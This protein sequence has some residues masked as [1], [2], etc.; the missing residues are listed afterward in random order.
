MAAWELGTVVKLFRKHT[1]LSQ[2]GVAR[3]VNIDQAEVSRLERGLK[4]IRDR[5]QFV[6]WTDALGVPKEL[7]GLLPT[8]DPHVPDSQG[9]TGT[10]DT[11]AHGY[12]ALPEGPGQLLLPAGR[13]LSTTA[14]PVLTLPAASFL[15]DSLML[16]S[17]PELGAWRTMP[18]RALI[19]ANRTVDGTVRQFVTDA[20]PSGARAAASDP[21]DIPAAYELD[22]L[23]YG[24]LWAVS[25]FEAALLGD[26]QALHAPLA[27]LTA[28]PGSPV[29]S[30]QAL[31][32]VSRMLIGSETCARYILGH[33][34]HLGDSPVFWTREQR[35]EEAATWL[36]FRHKYQ[37]LER[38]APRR[39]GGA[40]GRGFCIPETAV[41]SS[42]AYERVLLF[43]AIALM[44]SFGIRTWVT[45]D[46]GFAHT[47]GFALSPGRRAVIASWV[48][49]EGGIPP[50]GHRA[51][52]NPAHVR[53]RDRPCQPPLG[54]GGRAGRTAPC[55]NGGVPQSRRLL[56]RAAVR[57]AFSRR[58]GTARA[59]AQPVARPRRAGRRLPVRGRAA[60][61]R[62]AYPDGADPIACVNHS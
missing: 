16:D 32:D 48:R 6:Q 10:A 1:G 17:R 41:V 49:T 34:D 53:R 36:F 9:R 40:S 57:T 56:A 58:H 12:A 22:D 37:Y 23:T 11:R 20:R 42:P 28:S 2:A 54:H 7:L 45:D 26:D 21:V 50:R 24:I 8:A 13:S 62:S 55:G 44:E 33:R 30:D 29:A 46:G 4:Q 61:D 38:T 19:V 59:A 15:G 5:R 27:S 18:M 25:G 51:A 3:M 60:G 52:G 39:P 35:G 43:L 31:T 47:D 14:L